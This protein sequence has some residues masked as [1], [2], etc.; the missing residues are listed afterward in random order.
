LKEREA[1]I[2]YKQSVKEAWNRQERKWLQSQQEE[3]EKWQ[4]LEEIKAE[5]KKESVKALARDRLLQVRL[6]R[7]SL[8]AS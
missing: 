6:S 7:S 1:Q 4:K 5:E 3:L 8:I 2:Q